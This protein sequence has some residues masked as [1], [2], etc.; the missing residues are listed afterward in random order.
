MHV[1]VCT[2]C[3][4]EYRP[5][6][7]ICADCGGALEDRFEETS[8]AGAPEPEPPRI[9]GPQHRLYSATEAADLEPL[10]RR[11]GAVGIPF[12]VRGAVHS[13]QLLVGEGDRDRA[14]EA[15]KDL[16]PAEIPEL[17]AGF[18]PERGYARCPACGTDLAQGATACPE[19]GL[20]VGT[21]P[22]GEVCPRCLAALEPGTRCASCG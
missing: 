9:S 6:I 17:T 15:L 11:L 8:T 22:G 20:V 14:D 18:D 12:A 5:D 2:D 16:L 21:E 3:G 13:Y 1:R 10:A 7:L 19:C 4:E